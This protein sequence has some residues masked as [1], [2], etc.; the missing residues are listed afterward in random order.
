MRGNHA[1]V[2]TRGW[3]FVLLAGLGIAAG[4]SA[5]EAEKPGGRNAAWDRVWADP[6]ADAMIRKCLGAVSAE[7]MTRHLFHLAKNPLPFRKLNLTLP[8]HEKSTLH[9]A[10]DYLAAQ[11][12]S[13][14]YA[15]EREPVRVQAFRRDASKPKHAQYAPPKPDDPWYTAYNLYAEKK[16]RSRPDEIILA[17]A[18]KDSQS[19]VD[20]PG[21][22]DNA[23]GTVGVLEMARVLAGH[24]PERT[25]RFLFCNEEHTPWTSVTAAQ[26]AKARKDRLLAVFNLDG[27][28]AKG[29]EETQAGKKTNVTAFTAPEGE[30]LAELMAAVNARFAIGLEQRSARRS[31]PGDDDGS[32]VKAGY[33][34]AVVNIGSWPYADPNYHAEGDVPE[35]CDVTNA[36]MTVR[37]TLAAILTLDRAG[38][39][40]PNAD[41]PRFLPNHGNS[42]YQAEGLL[43]RWPPEGP[44]ELWRVEVG[45]GKSAVVEVG[46]RAFTAAETDEKQW[47]VCLDP[48]TGATLWKTLLLPQKNRHFEWGPVTSP[49]VDGDRVYYIPY[50]N[51]EGDVWEMRCPIICLK[52]DGTERWRADQTFWGTEGSTPLVVG[53]TLYVGADNPDRVVLVALDKLTGKLRWSTIVQSDS[54]REL[55]APASLTYQ[56]VEGIPQVIVATYGTREVLGVHAASGQI[57]WRYPYP[58]GI[59]IGL[60]ST[61]VAYGSRLFLSGGE[62]KGRNFSACLEMRSEG[63]KIAFREL[64]RSTELQTNMYNTVAIHQDAV[65]GFGG[66]TKTGFLHCTQL[67][68]GRLLWK[69]ESKD[70]TKDQNLVVADGLIFALTQNDELVMA[71]ASRERYRELGRVRLNIE[72]GRPQ[73]PTIANGRLYVR[74]SRWVVCYRIVP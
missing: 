58:A 70:W 38:E 46:G 15:V 8:G 64:Y 51:H 34:A 68:D 17:L 57:M 16:G 22:N 44:K 45:H 47:A 73:Q 53:D 71:E 41:L 56:V 43:R 62:G 60:V 23:I 3:R 67:G 39:G 48:A 35:Q 54:P 13:W 2:T 10:D 1:R 65:F 59:I 5:G 40:Q 6:A 30:R 33:P 28:G 69:E 27:I 25:V 21:A 50:A 31:A 4:A 66:G 7:Q 49:V 36:A 29:A 42:V 20:S 55:G 9:E 24:A 11:L 52:T 72:L 61:P 63:G 18:H 37:A 19:W 26:K 14:G 32:F 74:G 12:E